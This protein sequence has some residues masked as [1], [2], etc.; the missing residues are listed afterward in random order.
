M[1]EES[2]IGSKDLNCRVFPCH[3]LQ[4][5]KRGP[6]EGRARR[7]FSNENAIPT[8]GLAFLHLH[9]PPLDRENSLAC[10]VCN[11]RG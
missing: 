2:L 1:V 3:A 9:E 10:I 7:L 8:N 4:V 6:S 11:M 5:L